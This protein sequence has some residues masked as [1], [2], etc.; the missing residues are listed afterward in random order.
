VFTFQVGE[1]RPLFIIGQMR[2]DALRH[3]HYE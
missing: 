3:H 1:M 2:P